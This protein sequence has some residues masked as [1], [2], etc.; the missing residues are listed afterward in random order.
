[1]EL[2]KYWNNCQF[3]FIE[4]KHCCYQN[5]KVKRWGSPHL[6]LRY[7]CRECT[8]PAF[9]TIFEREVGGFQNDMY[10]ERGRKYWKIRFYGIYIEIKQYGVGHNL[11]EV[12]LE[13]H[14]KWFSAEHPLSKAS[15]RKC[16]W[17]QHTYRLHY[18]HSLHFETLLGQKNCYRS[19]SSLSPQL[20]CYAQGEVWSAKLE[21]HL[22]F[23][24]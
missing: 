11:I 14:L 22:K 13:C 1:M 6:F 17:Q 4:R 9:L 5:H 12:K 8:A 10:V 21:N 20:S 24:P 3:F 23:I 18:E 19:R 16:N 15:V 2:L 7:S